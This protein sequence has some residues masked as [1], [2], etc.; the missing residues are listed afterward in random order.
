MGE[1]VIVQIPLDVGKQPAVIT[2]SC[3]SCGRSFALWVGLNGIRV[4][5]LDA[6][7]PLMLVAT[8]EG[9]EYALILLACFRRWCRVAIK[10]P[11]PD[12]LAVLG[13]AGA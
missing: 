13:A 8:P 5:I 2:S 6:S 11:N 10:D 3:S 12:H 7:V 1:G 9:I 4:R